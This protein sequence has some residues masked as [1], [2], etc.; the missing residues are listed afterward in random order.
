M[1]TDQNCKDLSPA[2]KLLIQQKTVFVKEQIRFLNTVIDFGIL[3]NESKPKITD[4]II[5]TSGIC[6]S[7]GPSISKPPP[8]NI[9][10]LNAS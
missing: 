1:Q 7:E 9:D 5:E 3:V 6:Q 10:S 8:A 2:D 4:Q